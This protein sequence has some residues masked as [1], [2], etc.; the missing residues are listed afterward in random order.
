VPARVRGDAVRLR[1]IVLNLVGNAVKFTER[2]EVVLRVRFDRPRPGRSCLRF[3]VVDTGIGIPAAA[4]A[5]LFQPFV[6]ADASTARRFG[7]T[8]L[9]LAIC[10]RLAGLMQG[11]IGVNSNEGAGSTFWFTVELEH[12]LESATKQAGAPRLSERKRRAEVA[13]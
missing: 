2:G 13:G 6:Q 7:G 11:E 1:Q 10:K 5:G 8:G 9:G 4:Q 12:A 3:E